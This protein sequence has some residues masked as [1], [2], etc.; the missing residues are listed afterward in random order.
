MPT[1][2]R[3][4]LARVSRRVI[5]AAVRQSKEVLA[6]LGS[7]PTGLSAEE[8]ARRLDEDGPNTL[9][10]GP[11]H[12]ALAILTRAVGNPL[13]VLLAVL[14]GTSFAWGDTA[15]GGMM[16][17]MM[18]IGVGLRFVQESRADAAAAALRAMI[19]IHATVV[20]DGVPREIPIEDL[21][22]GD[23]VLLAAGDMVPAD[24]R[25][26]ASKEIGR[27]HV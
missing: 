23:V 6:D 10:A 12:A 17:V 20:R 25:I 8:A 26:L 22:R 4:P 14:A 11:Q 5:E 16:L 24:V 19:R 9:Q 21:V 27:A 2:T 1:R 3:I 13:V 7:S 18:T 15:A